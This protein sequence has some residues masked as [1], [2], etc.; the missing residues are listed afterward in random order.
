MK[1]SQY[2]KKLI[3]DSIK[4]TR[5]KIRMFLKC[6]LQQEHRDRCTLADEKLVQAINWLNPHS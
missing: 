4:D 3:V 2:S 5:K 6:E 1:S